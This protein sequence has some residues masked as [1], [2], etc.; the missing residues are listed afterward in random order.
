M[1]AAEIVSM[2]VGLLTTVACLVRRRWAEATW[3]G[4]QVAALGTTYWY[5]SINRAVLLWFPLFLLV[6]AVLG[7]P[8][9]K[10]TGS[11]RMPTAILIGVLLTLSTLLGAFWAWLFYSGLWAS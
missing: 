11:A 5:M 1:F 4:L 2:G 10:R 8:F 6:G 3:V 7:T 9:Q